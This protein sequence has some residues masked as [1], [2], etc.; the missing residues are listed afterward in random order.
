MKELKN[1]KE[2]HFEACNVSGNADELTKSPI[3]FLE[4]SDNSKNIFLNCPNPSDCA[5]DA[6]KYYVEGPSN[7]LYKNGMIKDKARGSMAH[8]EILIDQFLNITK[9]NICA[10]FKNG[11]FEFIRP[12]LRA[13]EYSST[14][15]F[16]TLF[17]Y[18]I[19]GETKY[20]I[21]SAVAYSDI[22]NNEVFLQAGKII[23]LYAKQL[24]NWYFDFI[25]KILYSEFIDVDK[26]CEFLAN[27]CDIPYKEI[28]SKQK[29]MFV[30]NCLLEESK[31]DIKKD[32]EIIELNAVNLV[33]EF[34]VASHSEDDE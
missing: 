25:N 1:N 31:K 27:L 34:A 32:I 7:V 23:T 20:Q 4:N 17:N 12:F 22:V 2:L 5:L 13:S 18:E 11:L 26:L 15:E 30:A 28:D 8:L 19:N 16:T 33:F 14:S 6:F 10:V 29:Y 9:L 21:T 24:S 3:F